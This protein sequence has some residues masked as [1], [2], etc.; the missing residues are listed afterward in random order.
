MLLEYYLCIN[1]RMYINSILIMQTV[2]IFV[3]LTLI[4]LLILLLPMIYEIV[5]LEVDTYD[6]SDEF[7]VIMVFPVATNLSPLCITKN[8]LYVLELTALV[9]NKCYFRFS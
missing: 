5:V 7:V 1:V 9:Q 6:V 2:K 3:S 8:F 4:Y